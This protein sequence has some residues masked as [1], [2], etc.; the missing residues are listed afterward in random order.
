MIIRETSHESTDLGPSLR[1]YAG[2]SHEIE[3]VATETLCATFWAPERH[4]KA[5]LPAIRHAVHIYAVRTELTRNQK[6]TAAVELARWG[7]YSAHHISAITGLRRSTLSSKLDKTDK[8]GG[9]FRPEDLCDIERLAL[10]RRDTALM[11]V[12]LEGCGSTMVQ[13]LTGISASTLARARRR[14]AAGGD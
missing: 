3:T 12:V 5:N 6:F 11:L 14:A 2:S 1:A 7:V 9:R 4:P 13:R 10:A 8:M